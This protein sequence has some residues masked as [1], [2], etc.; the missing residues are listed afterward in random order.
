MLKIHKN[1]KAKNVK[2]FKITKTISDQDIINAN[3]VRE[4]N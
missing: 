3:Y 4:Y 1:F 2:I